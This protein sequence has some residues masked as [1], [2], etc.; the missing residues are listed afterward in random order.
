MLV[1]ETM[2]I[3]IWTTSCGT[4][5]RHRH[6]SQQLQIV[7]GDK[8]LVYLQRW[9]AQPGTVI[10]ASMSMLLV[11]QSGTTTTVDRPTMRMAPAGRDWTMHSACDAPC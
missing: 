5:N 8:A 4:T 7:R 6:K 11:T 2:R 10:P 1:A 3:P 9:A